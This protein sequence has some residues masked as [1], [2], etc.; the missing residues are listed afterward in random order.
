MKK[1]SFVTHF[2]IL[3]LT[4]LLSSC[5]GGASSQSQTST[6]FTISGTVTGL[7]PGSQIT[8]LNNGADAQTVTSNS[9]FAFDVA[10]VRNGSYAVTVGTLTAGQLCHV[11]NDTGVNV[12]ANVTDVSIVC[13]AAADTILHNFSGQTP[14]GPHPSFSLT[15]GNDGDFYGVTTLGGTSNNGTIYK[16][17]SAGVETVLYS[18]AGGTLDGTAPSASL[19]LGN[20]GNFYGV[21]KSGGTSNNGTVFKITPA[22]VESVLYSFSF[23]AYPYSLTLGNDGNFYGVTTNGGTSNNSG[24][25]FKIT[26]SGVETVLYSFAGGTLDGAVPCASLTLGNDGNFYGVTESGGT[27]NNG[28]V[29]K[30]TPAGVESVLYSFSFSAYPYSLTLGNDGNFYGATAYGGNSNNGGTVFKITP[31]G[32]ETV[33]YSFA[34]GTS[35]GTN[36]Q[37]SLTLGSDGNFYGVTS[38]GGTSNNGT[39]YKIT[40]AGVETVLYSFAVGTS[41][42]SDPYGSLTLGNDGNFYGVTGGTASVPT[43]GVPWSYPNFGTI[44]KITPSGVNTLL[45]S[46]TGTA[47]DGFFPYSSLTIGNNGNFYGVTVEGGNY[48]YGTAYKITPAGVETVLYSFTGGTSDGIAPCGSLTLGNDGNFYGATSIGGTNGFGTAFKITPAGIETVLYSFSGGTSDGANPQ[49]SLT[50]GSDGNF[51]GVTSNGG[52]NKIGTIYKITPAGIETV[53]YSFAGG[54]SDGANPQTSL[55]L[56]NDGNFYGVASNGGTSNNGT[57]YKITP[58]G[59]E[60]VLYSFAGGTS[61]GANPLASLTLGSDDNFYGVTSNGGTS[62][63]GTVYKITPAGIETVLYSFTGGTSDGA[64]P[65]ASLTLGSDGNFYG[66][67]SN[68]GTSKKGTI[69]KITPAGVETVLYSFAGGTSDGANPQASLTLGS[70]GHFYGVTTQ[71]GIFSNIHPI[72]NTMPAQNGTVFRY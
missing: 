19:T 1:N 53:L 36:P 29:F 4:L 3:L 50:L 6:M 31:S 43:Q 59:I 8:I 63:N 47:E 25:V 13:E 7:N 40:P 61:D 38:N 55:T 69:Y 9:G 57:V 66:V 11:T 26:P 62:N 60:T 58:A 12:V 21:T 10:V 37:T 24:T 49:G 32:V 41:D 35:D 15:L 54:T 28:T 22:G 16:V 17:T 51:Y 46:F 20:D 64:N 65:Q 30:I 34:G 67:T 39:V 70:D 48:G 72:G 56:G 2:Q 5:G 71:G 33:L 68:G 45:Y 23:S 14:V 42:S 18:F 27:S 52:T 44:Y